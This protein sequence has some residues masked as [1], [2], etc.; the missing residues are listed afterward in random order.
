[1]MSSASVEIL[2][3]SSAGRSHT[4]LAHVM[5]PVPGRPKIQLRV[6]ILLGSWLIRSSA[7][8][9]GNP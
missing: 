6:K 2:F 4:G 3:A 1:M 8:N 7:R 9:A 5:P